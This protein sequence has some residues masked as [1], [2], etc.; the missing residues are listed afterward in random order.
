[1]PDPT[2]ETPD[3][4]PAIGPLP[5]AI[6]AELELNAPAPLDAER[7]RMVAVL[8]FAE[9][10]SVMFA[11]R[12]AGLHFKTVEAIL[13]EPEAEVE[14]EAARAAIR[15]GLAAGYMDIQIMAQREAM[16][17]LRNGD[18]Y[19]TRNGMIRAPVSARVAGTLFKLAGERH[20]ILTGN[21]APS[22]ASDPKLLALADQLMA[23]AEARQL[24][25]V[26]PALPITNSPNTLNLKDLTTESDPQG[27]GDLLE[28][29]TTGQQSVK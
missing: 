14:I 28:M 19:I 11:A 17:R 18:I 24:E 29:C 6:E 21:I 20:D 8:A 25:V 22:A 10:R 23:V 1:M 15:M 27:L 16:D 12:A 5:K 4:E 13:R 26:K 3:T 9:S 2:A 7:R